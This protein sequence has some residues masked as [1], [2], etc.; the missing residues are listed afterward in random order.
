MFCASI[1]TLTTQGFCGRRKDES[2]K[3]RSI[4]GDAHLCLKYHPRYIESIKN[5]E[6]KNPTPITMMIKL[7]FQYQISAL[8][9]GIIAKSHRLG[10]HHWANGSS[11]VSLQTAFPHGMALS[12]LFSFPRA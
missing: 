2:F 11:D 7:R 8:P 4:S 10:G 12:R 9:R 3:C 1:S 5:G 6:K